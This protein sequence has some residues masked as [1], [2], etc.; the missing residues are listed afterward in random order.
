MSKNQV[1]FQKGQSLR[2]FLEVYGTNAQCEQ[3][4]FAARWPQGFQCAACGYSKYCRL[5][6]R[7]SLQCI[8]CKRQLGVNYNTAWSVKHKLIQA[9]RERDDSQP[10]LGYVELDDAYLGGQA[11]GGKRGRGADRKQP[12]V[13]AAQVSE[14]GRPERLRLS[15]VGGFRLKELEAWA[16]RH[17]QPRTVVRSDGLNCFRGVV[18]AQWH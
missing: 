4:L 8:R 15:P 5:H 7:K 2:E 14:D 13:A 18:A 11:T 10:L 6:T 12:F 16:R 17:L 3:E 9:M 1:Q